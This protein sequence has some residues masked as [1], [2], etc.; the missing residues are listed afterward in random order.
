MFDLCDIGNYPGL[1]DL[2]DAQPPLLPVSRPIGMHPVRDHVG[3]GEEGPAHGPELLLRGRE[4]LH[5]SPGGCKST[6]DLYCLTSE[7]LTPKT[8]L[9]RPHKTQT[10]TVPF[11][12]TR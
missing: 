12:Y 2:C 5:H 9:D 1:S 8:N 11:S 3:E 4:C 6:S 10:K 7:A